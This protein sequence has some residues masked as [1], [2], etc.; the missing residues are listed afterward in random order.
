M[1]S[2]QANDDRMNDRKDKNN[3][4][5]IINNGIWC[6][7]LLDSA[8]LPRPAVVGWSGTRFRKVSKFFLKVSAFSE[9]IFH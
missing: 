1:S 4:L 2:S 5:F 8:D 6:N 3:F 7:K 9:S